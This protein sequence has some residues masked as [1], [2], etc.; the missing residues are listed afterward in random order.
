MQKIYIR[1]DRC[2][3]FDEGNSLASGAARI[4]VRGGGHF[5]GSASYGVRGRR[6]PDARKFWK[7]PKNLSRKLQKMDYFRRFFKNIKKPGITFS[8]FGRK[9]QLFGKFLT[10]FSKISL[11]IAQKMHYFGLFSK[12]FQNPALNFRAFWRKT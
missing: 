10:K 1:V 4:S 11:K 8:R 12:K 3:H 7:F 2:L 5:R 6:P 9:T